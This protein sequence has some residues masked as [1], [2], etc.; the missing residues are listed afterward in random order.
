M[1]KSYIYLFFVILILMFSSNS[2]AEKYGNWSMNYYLDEFGDETDSKYLVI[3]DDEGSFSNSATQWSLLYAMILIDK[4]YIDE[5][6]F[7]LF[8]YGSNPLQGYY[9][10]GHRYTCNMK[11]SKDEKI[12]MSLIMQ[13]DWDFLDIQ[14]GNKSIFIDWMGRE[15]YIKFSCFNKERQIEKYLFKIDFAGYNE[16]MSALKN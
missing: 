5:P 8:E 11:N 9:S 10:D 13:K 14:S 12:S 7:K 15:E 2:S 6:Y 3:G 1:I 4:N 16:A